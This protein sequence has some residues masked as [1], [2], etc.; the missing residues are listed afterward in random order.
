[1]LETFQRIEKSEKVL[2]VINVEPAVA[3]KSVVGRLLGR[4]WAK[5]G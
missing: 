4:Q 3:G 5:R 2:M 1:M